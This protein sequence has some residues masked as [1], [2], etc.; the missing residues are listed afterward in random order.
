MKAL[1][2]RVLAGIGIE[3]KRI[4]SNR[5]RWLRDLNIKTVLDVGANTGQFATLIHHILPDCDIYS[6][7]PLADCFEELQKKMAG[8]RRFRAF[9]CALGR[10]DQ[11]LEMHRSEFSPSSSLLAMRELHARLF[12][13]T[14]KTWLERVPVR[15]LDGVAAG[16]ELRDNVLIK[17]DVQGYE[18]RVIGGGLRTMSRAKVLIVETS[19]E[20]LY[21]TQPLFDSIYEML[22]DLGFRY[23]GSIDQLNSPVD[24]SVLQC[25][26]VFLRTDV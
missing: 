20:A 23:R 6:F 2:K 11:E 26:A 4:P 17:M 22:K 16:L 5:F 19:F 3:V 1:V 14:A 25:D 24:G 9:R 18:D 21:S 8:V 10:E 15:T 12:P 7:E 13:Y